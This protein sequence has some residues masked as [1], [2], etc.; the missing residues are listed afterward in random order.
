MAC[1]MIDEMVVLK[2]PKDDEAGHINVLLEVV[3]EDFVKLR[4]HKIGRY[5]FLRLVGEKVLDEELDGRHAQGSG[6]AM[7][8]DV[9]HDADVAVGADREEFV[10]VA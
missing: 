9:A 3:A 7:S 4:Q 8:G 6:D 10:E 1:G 5:G 2:V